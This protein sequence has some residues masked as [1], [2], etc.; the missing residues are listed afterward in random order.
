MTLPGSNGSSAD[1]QNILLLALKY[2]M[3]ILAKIY[4][5]IPC[6]F[7]ADLGYAM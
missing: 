3:K 7:V 6:H 1:R 2:G 4:L 5:R